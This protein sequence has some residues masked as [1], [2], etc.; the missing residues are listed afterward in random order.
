MALRTK[1][2]LS[3]TLLALVPL[4]LFGLVAYQVSTT[5]LINVERQN[6]QDAVD[7]TNRALEDIKSN[8]GKP[9]RDYSNWDELHD[10][11]NLPTA[12]MDWIK[13]NFDPSSPSAVANTFS[14]DVIGL[15][16]KDHKL[17]YN[18]GS[19]DDV[20][21][22]TAPLTKDVMTVTEPQTTLILSGSDVYIA[23]VDAIFTSNI[24]DPNGMLL[25]ARKLGA[26]DITQI[27]ALTSY[28]I[29]LYPAT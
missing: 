4:I 22:L 2:L 6:L 10:R 21:K 20:A 19:A 16:N 1:L 8:M 13:T 3:L 5:N 29:S 17:V 24:T 12:D 27:K 28:D 9:V 23:G 15:W 14:L 11:I 18:L 26:D 25:F 7:S